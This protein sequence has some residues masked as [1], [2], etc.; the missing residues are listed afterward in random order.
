MKAVVALYSKNNLPSS[1][2]IFGYIG[3]KV[4]GHLGAWKAQDKLALAL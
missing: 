1:H 3:V 2:R 4:D